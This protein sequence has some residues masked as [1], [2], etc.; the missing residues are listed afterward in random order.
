MRI[1]PFQMERTQCLYENEVEHNL[2][3]SGVLPLRL[4]DLLEDAGDTDTVHALRLKY[5]H[6]NGSPIL[7]ERIAAFYDGAGRD[8]VLVTNGC[9]EANYTTLWGLLEKG[10]RLAFMIPNYM[11][12]RGLARAYGDRADTFRLVERRD[13][14]GARWALDLDSLKEAVTRRTK[15][16]MVTNPNNPTGAVL[17]EAEMDAIVRAARRVNAWI[18]SDEVYRGAEV[19]REDGA[20]VVTSPTFWGRHDKVIVTGGLSKAFGLPGLRIGWIAAAPDVIKECWAM[21]DYVSLSPGK[22]ND[23]LARLALKHRD[24]IIERNQR[25]I[26]ANLSTAGRWMRERSEFLTWTPPRGGL[27]ALIKYELPIASLQLADKLATEYSVMLAPGSA[28]GYEHHLRLGIG[29][30]PDIFAKGLALA[31]QCFDEVRSEK[32]K[33]RS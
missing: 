21:R 17:N 18:V 20:S 10:D 27:L 19:R 32:S 28:F 6:S 29:Q 26:Q 30:Q 8:N 1:D 23:A 15:V 12:A 24:R 2:S 33:A 5:P 22:L 11:Q 7:R 14:A 9:S 16:I 4:C 13:G 31:G 25:I 3:E